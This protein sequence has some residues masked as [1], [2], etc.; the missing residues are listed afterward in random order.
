MSLPPVDE[1]ES[2][3]IP[4]DENGGRHRKR[5]PSLNFVEADIGDFLKRPKTAVAR[6]YEGKA[7]AALNSA[8]RFTAA[9][10]STL[11]DAAAIIAYGDGLAAATGELAEHNAKTRR[12]I[13]LI[14]T[15]ESPY[16][17]FL[18]A[19]LPL[20]AQLFRN[21]ETTLQSVPT[22]FGKENRAR[23][24]AIRAARRQ[25]S[26]GVTLKI[27]L[28]RKQI[29]IPFALKV[30][31]GFLR[32]GTL[33]PDALSAAVFSNEQ[34]TKALRKRGI[35]VAWPEVPTRQYHM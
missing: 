29:R 27:P 3:R 31:L 7:A 21:H 5:E 34:V 25:A 26:P 24:K 33:D 12:A 32:A 22:Q 16:L 20:T 8:L 13:D 23:R 10:P 14:L 19:A 18:I 9:K 11:P 28:L 17:A 1:M 6:E 30:N 15:P 4:F 35:E 2:E